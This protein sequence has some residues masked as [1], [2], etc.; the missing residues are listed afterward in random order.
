MDAFEILTENAP[1]FLDDGMPW[2]AGSI[3]RN[4]A[5]ARTMKIIAEK[6]VD[7]YYNGE[8][9]DN[10]D[11]FMQENDGWARKSDLQAYRALVENTRQ[12][13]LPRL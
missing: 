11:R 8:L 6:G 12:G 7:A 5:L 10:L 9:A 13:Q 4:P 1:E 2:M 3:Y